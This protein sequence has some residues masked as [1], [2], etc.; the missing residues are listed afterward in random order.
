MRNILLIF[1]CALNLFM[2]CAARLGFKT[3]NTQ[4]D[5]ITETTQGVAAE[6]DIDTTH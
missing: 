1:T 3:T 4:N 6:L 5:G 2:G